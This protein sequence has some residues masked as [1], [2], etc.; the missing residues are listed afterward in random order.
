MQ[1]LS[2]DHHGRDPYRVALRNNNAAVAELLESHMKRL[3]D[4]R[5]DQV[6]RLREAGDQGDTGDSPLYASPT[7]YGYSKIGEHRPAGAGADRA[8]ARQT[9]ETQILAGES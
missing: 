4:Y 2:Q 7:A 9:A 6:T 1:I 8:Q 3:S 5:G